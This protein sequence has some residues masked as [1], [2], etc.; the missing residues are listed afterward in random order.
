MFTCDTGG[1]LNKVAHFYSYESMAHRE[2]VRS[3]AA[4]NQAWSAYVDIGRKFMVKQVRGWEARGAE[5]AGGVSG[6]GGV[7]C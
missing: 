2:E 1:E 7:G 4:R 5:A 3:A 6:R